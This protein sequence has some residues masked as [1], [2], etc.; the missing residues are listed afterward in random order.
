VV[1]KSE[2][3]KNVTASAPGPTRSMYP[4]RVRGFSRYSSGTSCAP[5]NVGTY[6]NGVSPFNCRIA[7][8]ILISSSSDN[9]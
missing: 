9:P 3:T 6:R 1:K 4:A 2:P 7:R 8:K 5:R